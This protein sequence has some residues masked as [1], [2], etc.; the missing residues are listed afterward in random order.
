M[1]LPSIVLRLNHQVEVIPL[2]ED[3]SEANRG[4]GDESG[5]NGRK[6]EKS[7]IPKGLCT[8][9]TPFSQGAQKN[10]ASRGASAAGVGENNESIEGYRTQRTWRKQQRR[11]KQFLRLGGRRAPGGGKGGGR[12]R[13]G[14]Y[15]TVEHLVFSI[16]QS[17][18]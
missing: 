17:K 4:L 12:G 6:Y 15:V 11:Q 10:R 16:L 1:V 7:V 14:G 8:R 5:E 18:H 13:G 3:E 9:L 2:H